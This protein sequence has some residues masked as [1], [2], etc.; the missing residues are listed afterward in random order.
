MPIKSAIA[1]QKA[2]EPILVEGL[3][4]VAHYIDTF[5][6]TV[7]RRYVQQ[8]RNTRADDGPHL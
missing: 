8:M 6:S 5:L 2:A 4:G 1:Q 3:G 7:S